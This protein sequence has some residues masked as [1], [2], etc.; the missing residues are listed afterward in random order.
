MKR[1]KIYR[2]NNEFKRICFG[3]KILVRLD[4]IKC[5]INS[6]EP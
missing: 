6:F 5:P 3:H 4:W 2:P 1:L